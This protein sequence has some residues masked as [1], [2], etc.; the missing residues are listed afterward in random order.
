MT[1]RQWSSESGCADHVDVQATAMGMDR[2]GKLAML[3]GKKC[4]A[5][6][7]LG[8]ENTTLGERTLDF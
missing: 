3:G 4:W 1:S 5:L 2:V 7:D 8:G 6:V